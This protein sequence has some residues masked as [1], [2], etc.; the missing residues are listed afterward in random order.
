MFGQRSSD[1]NSHW[2]NYHWDAKS[3]FGERHGPLRVDSATISTV[4]NANWQ[5]SKIFFLLTFFRLYDF[6]K[7]IV[8][9]PNSWRSYVNMITIYKDHSLLWNLRFLE[10]GKKVTS[11]LQAC[12]KLLMFYTFWNHAFSL[13]NVRQRTEGRF[14]FFGLIRNKNLTYLFQSGR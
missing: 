9:L 2:S 13:C 4:K 11:L 3:F 14:V 7:V 8:P 6:R 5:E 10:T 1:F 12:L